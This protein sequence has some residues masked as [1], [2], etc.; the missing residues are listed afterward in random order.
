MKTA[1]LIDFFIDELNYG[2]KLIQFAMSY[3]LKNK[4]RIYTEVYDT[5]GILNWNIGNFNEFDD[6]YLNIRKINS[7]NDVVEDQENTDFFI[8]PGD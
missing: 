6:V 1:K 7:F 5:R 4:F 2:N 8:F 3:I